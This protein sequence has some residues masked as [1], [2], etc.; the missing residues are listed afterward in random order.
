MALTWT[1]NEINLIVEDY[2][3]MLRTEL[4]GGTFNKANHRRALLPL[5][6]S[7]SEGSIEFKHQNI[8]A[9]LAR[10]GQPFIRGYL[11]RYNY[12]KVLEDKVLDY[13]I[14]NR[15]I[16]EDFRIFSEKEVVLPK[17]IH[18]DKLIVDAPVIG[19]VKEP[20]NAYTRSPIKV[21]YLEKEQNNRKLGEK[22]EELV[23]EY[24]KW[25]LRRL[26]K[27]SLADTIRWIAIEEGDGAGFDILSRYTN[28][29]DKYIEV[30]TTKLSKEA[31]FYFSRNEL[32]FSKDHSENFHLF[33]LFNFEK[34]T[35][36]FTKVG[37][38]DSICN[39]IPVTYR[40]YF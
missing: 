22:G 1:D 31:P 9:V 18:F 32:L 4:A 20:T 37:S 27:D 24:E 15:N 13:L 36:M 34:N 35:K 6:N 33:R 3:S 26:G 8:S 11:P 14:G 19:E 40:G 39:S 38:L 7:R 28:G 17:K 12:Q 30:K 23:L 29:K 2:F 5:L 10:L 16:E 25:E 21:N